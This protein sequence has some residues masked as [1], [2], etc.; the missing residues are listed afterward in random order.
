[1]SRYVELSLDSL[2]NQRELNYRE[3]IQPF[4]TTFGTVENWISAMRVEKYGIPDFLRSKGICFKGSILELGAGSCWLSALLSKCPDVQEVYALDFSRR[5][6][7]EIAPAVIDYLHGDADKIVRVRGS[8][9][10]LVRL[11]KKFDFVV[12][13]ETLHHAD[14]PCRLFSQISHVL[15]DHGLIVSMREPIASTLP[16][17]N[18]IQKAT[19]GCRERKFGVTENI[20]RLAE[21]KRM[22]RGFG[23]EMTC[24]SVKSC[25][26]FRKSVFRTVSGVD[27]NLT[28]FVARKM[29]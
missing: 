5:I 20:F 10:D 12:C 22:F 19:F 27:S 23:F 21:W 7:V 2:I 9:Y 1:M 18:F 29:V 28:V 11:G 25:S 6:L 24:Y 8:F 15:K 4:E 17:L 16:F 3:K 26:R 14:H 13:D